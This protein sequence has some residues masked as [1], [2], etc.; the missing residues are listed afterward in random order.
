MISDVREKKI[1]TILSLLL[2]LLFMLYYN[3]F[4]THLHTNYKQQNKKRYK[5]H[6]TIVNLIHEQKRINDEQK[7]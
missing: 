4:V 7:A 3:S 2:L 6:K 5:S 1:Y